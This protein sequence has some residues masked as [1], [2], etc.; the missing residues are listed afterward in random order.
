MKK[1]TYAIIAICLATALTGCGRRGD[2]Q[3]PATD[4]TEQETTQTTQ[5]DATEETEETLAHN[6]GE[7]E[8]DFS[9]FE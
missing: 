9:D 2:I 6:T 7:A 1:W 8:L 3:N 5:T 4:N